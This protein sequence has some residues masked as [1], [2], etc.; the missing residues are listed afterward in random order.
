M[1]DDHE[2]LDNWYWERRQGRRRA[3]QGE[4]GGGARRARAAGVRRIQPA[5]DLRRRSRADLP[6]DPD[7]PA[8][9][10][11]RARHA[12]LQ[13]GE[14]REPPAGARRLVRDLRPGA[15]AVAEGVARGEQGDVEDRRGR[16]A[17]RPDRAAT[18]RP[19][20]G[21]RQRR[22]RRAAR[23]RARD[24]RPAPRSEAQPRPQRRVDHRRRP[25]LRRAP[26]PPDAREVHRLRS[27]LGVR[28]RAAQR[29]HVRSRHA[30]RRRSARR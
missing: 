21:G 7:G 14:Q 3:L 19:L 29:R 18:A 12:Q 25:L 30:R 9:R 8:R 20:R 27:V 10:G 6:L 26:L 28:R 11:L 13:G 1:W 5:A 24:R 16:S 22:A 15:A 17:A 2:V 23:T 4:V